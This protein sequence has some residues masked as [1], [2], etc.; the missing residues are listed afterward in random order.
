[1][2]ISKRVVGLVLLLSSLMLLA[3]AALGQELAAVP[4][5]DD[6]VLLDG[7]WEIWGDTLL[8]NS[9][10]GSNTN[11]YV[12]LPQKGTK[13][14]YEWTIMFLE[15]RGGHGPLAG[16]HILASDGT[17]TNRGNS[18][19][20]WQDRNSIQLYKSSPDLKTLQ[21]WEV[22]TAVG[23]SHFYRVVVD[24]VAKTITVYRDGQL[25][26]E[27][28]DPDLYTE[29]SFISTRTNVTAAAFSGIRFGAVTE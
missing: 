1:M 5:F 8:H 9:T 12:P 24:T 4:G 2:R 7:D 17:A 11:A 21:R 6:W 22:T 28:N 10:A 19:L 13:L 3:P 26:G 18:Y 14:V 23:E 20:I 15:T 16:V 29:G 25:I 27:Y